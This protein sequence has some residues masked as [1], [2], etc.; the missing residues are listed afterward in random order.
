M[1]P[2]E[3][4]GGGLCDVISFANI[5]AFWK[6]D[7]SNKRNIIFLDEPFK[8]INSTKLRERCSE[9]LRDISYKFDLQM[10]IVTSQD[11]IKGDKH[12]RVKNGIV[13]VIED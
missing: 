1:N 13:S 4:N 10:I 6:M 7:R 9:M 3:D 8:F 12:F 2:K 5:I 11:E